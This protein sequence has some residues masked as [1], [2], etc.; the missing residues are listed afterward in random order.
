MLLVLAGGVLNVSATSKRIYVKTD[1]NWMQYCGGTTKLTISSLDI[2]ALLTVSKGTYGTWG[3]GLLYA[4][5]DGIPETAV[6]FTINK[7]S[8][9]WTT[10][11]IN[12]ILKDKTVIYWYSSSGSGNTNVEIMPDA[13]YLVSWT[14]DDTNRTVTEVTLSENTFSVDINAP[15]TD[16]YYCIAPTIA[17]NHTKKNIDFWDEVYLPKGA[18]GNYLV[19]NFQNW[20][21]EIDKTNTY[22]WKYTTGL[23][24]KS[25]FS[26]NLSLKTFTITPYLSA[27]LNTNGYGTFGSSLYNFCIPA[28]DTDGGDVSAYYAASAGSSLVTM[29]KLDAGTD[30][31]KAD[32]LFLIGTASKTLKFTPATTSPSSVSSMMKP[33]DGTTTIASGASGPYR[34]VFSGDTFKKLSTTGRVIPEGKAYLESAELLANEFTLSFDDGTTSIRVINTD[35]TTVE[36]NDI[37]NVAGQRVVNPTKGLYIVNGKKVIK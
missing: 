22:C 34:Y 30:V 29:N 24:T 13:W 11:T 20:S 18:S 31:N 8:S 33:G 4:D 9:D 25:T 23:T 35:A 36:S 3:T 17:L 14:T 2:D 5:I 32:G 37:Y 7:G 26:G 15:T 19:N 10:G 21:G 1:G 16:T 28:K 27:S 6:N 12:G